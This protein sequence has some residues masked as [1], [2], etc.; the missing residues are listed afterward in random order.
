ACGTP[1]V[2][3]TASCLPEVAGDA[4]LLIDP[5][6]VAALAEALDRAHTDDTLRAEL[7]TRG[8]RRA[9]GFRWDD[10]ARQ[11]VGLYRLIA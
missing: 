8:K 5:H 6:D 1:V 9:S 11:L 7:V 10:A 3:S 2:A 4:A